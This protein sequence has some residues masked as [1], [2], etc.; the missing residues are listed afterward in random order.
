MQKI[1]Q[2]FL[3][4]R[5]LIS[6]CKGTETSKSRLRYN[7]FNIMTIVVDCGHYHTFHLNQ[8]AG[9]LLPTKGK[10]LYLYMY[11]GLDANY[12]YIP[13]HNSHTVIVIFANPSI[14]NTSMSTLHFFK[15]P[16]KDDENYESES[17][18]HTT[19]QE[20]NI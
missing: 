12:E 9:K 7:L 6:P 4:L 16:T 1:G 19:F 14:S 11:L 3:T 2:L 15:W 18:H 17:S 20:R 8:P 13:E 10:A 5:M